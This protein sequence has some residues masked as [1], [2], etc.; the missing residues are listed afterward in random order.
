MQLSKKNR[1]TDTRTR[2]TATC[3]Y[4]YEHKD[5]EKLLLSNNTDG[6]AS[7]FFDSDVLK[8]LMDTM[9]NSVIE[10]KDEKCLELM[11][12]YM[13]FGMY[14]VLRK[15]IVDDIDKTPGEIAEIICDIVV[16]R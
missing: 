2:I 4:L 1:F 14:H 15:W 5:T 11:Y 13:F 7:L 16:G 9:Y 3:E 10:N 6:E 8:S 12:T